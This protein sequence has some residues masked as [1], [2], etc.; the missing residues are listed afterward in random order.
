MVTNPLVFS[1]PINKDGKTPEDGTPATGWR[2]SLTSG[3]KTEV[4]V[5]VICV[6]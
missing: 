4:T 3:V 5:Y 2:A 1:G 6:S